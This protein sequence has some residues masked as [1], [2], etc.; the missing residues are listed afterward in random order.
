MTDKQKKDIFAKK[1]M[2]DIGD[3]D[4]LDFDELLNSVESGENIQFEDQESLDKKDGFYIFFLVV[5]N[6]KKN[7]AAN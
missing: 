4:V 6:K 3:G 2:K 5:P 1:V 7:T